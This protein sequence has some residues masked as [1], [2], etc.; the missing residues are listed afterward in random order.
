MMD[1]QFGK[2]SFSTKNWQIHN[3]SH[4][5]LHS[6]LIGFLITF[7]R[8]C[9]TS[10]PSKKEWKE[11]QKSFMIGTEGTDLVKDLNQNLK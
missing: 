5:E 8:K 2:E 4:T 7:G 6:I 1:I 9:L 10:F 3:F 11:S